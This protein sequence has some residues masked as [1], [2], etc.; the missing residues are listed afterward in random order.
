[1]RPFEYLFLRRMKFDY[2][3][4]PICEAIFSST[5]EPTIL[6]ETFERNKVVGLELENDSGLWL[7]WSAYP[8]ALCYS[9]YQAD[10]PEGPWVLVAECVEEFEIPDETICYLVSAITPEGESD[11]S[12][13]IC[14][15]DITCPDWITDLGG[16]S[17]ETCGSLF[18]L[19]VEAA[20]T[21]AAD[22]YYEWKKDGAIVFAETKTGASTYVVNSLVAGDAGL[23]HVD[24]YFY[25]EDEVC[26]VSTEQVLTVAGCGGGGGGCDC[27]GV[28][29]EDFMEDC[30]EF[31]VQHQ[32]EFP[33]PAET[34]FNF[35]AGI[36]EMRYVSG[37]SYECSHAVPTFND[38]ADCADTFQNCQSN[39]VSSTG[40]ISGQSD[41]DLGYGWVQAVALGASKVVSEYRLGG[42]N[43]CLK[44]NQVTAADV[45]AALEV[46]YPGKKNSVLGPGMCGLIPWVWE[47]GAEK[48]YPGRVEAGYTGGNCATVCGGEPACPGDACEPARC[49]TIIEIYRSRKF[50]AQPIVLTIQGWGA[51]MKALLIGSINPQVDPNVGYEWAGKFGVAP[52]QV[53]EYPGISQYGINYWFVSTNPYPG[54][55]Q[56]DV[57]GSSLWGQTGSVNPA[58]NKWQLTIFASWQDQ[59]SVW[60]AETLWRGYKL[61]G[62]T[63]AGAYCWEASFVPE[64]QT[65]LPCI[66]LI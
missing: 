27:L 12:D 6:L 16:S 5:G 39:A 31:V 38:P 23:Y 2:I 56:I 45:A 62:T 17:S 41:I 21:P 3:S 36:Y 66:V 43:E 58:D 40:L 25:T 19:T 1:M 63:G 42:G 24:A 14:P 53:D 57:S 7:R 59:S 61:S 9:V 11:L 35:G 34:L 51:A 26:K 64:L 47:S 20:V 10:G 22:I 8:G 44:S 30:N 54:I 4:P 52:N 32:G 15:E 37:S 48:T 28:M 50:I 33:A 46:A 49:D 29:P 60:Q 65:L 55:G 18:S 13:P